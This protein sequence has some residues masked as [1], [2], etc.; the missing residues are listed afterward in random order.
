MS[1][2]T[3]E[4]ILA[5]MA[6][7]MREIG[8]A[9]EYNKIRAGSTKFLGIKYREQRPR[10]PRIAVP[11]TFGGMP[12]VIDR[13]IA[14]YL[15]IMMGDGGSIFSRKPMRMA[16]VDCRKR[17]HTQDMSQMMDDLLRAGAVPDSYLIR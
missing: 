9:P 1:D 2:V 13:T 3:A 6:R 12:L 8:P 11:S 10:D 4:S 17:A 15:A 14:P 7:V 16:V 5:S